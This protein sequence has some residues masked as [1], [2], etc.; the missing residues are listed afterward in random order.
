MTP[1]TLSS[2]TAPGALMSPALIVTLLAHLMGLQP[3]TTDLYLPAL[4]A[5]RADLQASMASVQLTLSALLLAFGFSQLVWGPVSDRFGRRPTGT[6]PVG[7]GITPV[8][9]SY[10]QFSKMM[11]VRGNGFEVFIDFSASTVSEDQFAALPDINSASVQ[12]ACTAAWCKS[13]P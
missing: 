3:M 13:V 2:S 9:R 7:E 8:G 6:I 12:T 5:L 4:P 1:P 11:L 10:T